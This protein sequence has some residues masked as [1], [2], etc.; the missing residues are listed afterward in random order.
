MCKSFSSLDRII[1][2]HGPVSCEI[3]GKIALSVLRGLTY[4]YDVHRIIHRGLYKVH[5]L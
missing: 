2:K 4:L 3:F 5:S 1:R